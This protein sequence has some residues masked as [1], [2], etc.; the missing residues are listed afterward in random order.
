MEP[1]NMEL[2]DSTVIDIDSAVP[3]SDSNI[4]GTA[5]MGIQKPMLVPQNDMLDENSKETQICLLILVKAQT[6]H[7]C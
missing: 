5:S 1:V 3:A 4:D 2:Q 7:Q 6:C